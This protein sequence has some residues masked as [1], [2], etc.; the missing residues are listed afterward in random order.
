MQ[1]VVFELPSTDPKSPKQKK[2]NHGSGD[3]SVHSSADSSSL[4]SDDSSSIKK[5]KDPIECHPP[6]LVRVVG[7]DPRSKKNSTLEVCKEAVVEVAGGSYSQYLEPPRRKELAKIIVDA[8]AV[9]FPRG[10][11]FDLL[12]PWSGSNVKASNVQ[13][14][15]KASWRSSAEKILKRTGK[16]FRSAL[17]ISS[18]DIIV[19]VYAVGL[20]SDGTMSSDRSVIMNFYSSKCSEA[21]EIQIPEEVQMEYIGKVFMNLPAG[22]PRADAIRQFC[23]FL[24]A[25][26]AEDPG[27]PTLKVLEVDLQAKEKEKN[28]SSQGISEPIGKVL[29]RQKT[30]IYLEETGQLSPDDYMLTLSNRSLNEADGPEKGVLARIYEP[31]S[32]QTLALT[33]DGEDI[34]ELC[35]KFDEPDLLRDLLTARR[36]VN[37]LSEKN[38]SND[39]FVTEIEKVEWT[40]KIRIYNS[41]IC[42]YLVKDIGLMRSS[43][44]GT[45]SPLLGKKPQVSVVKLYSR[46]KEGKKGI[47]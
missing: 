1:I 34:Q 44:S 8:L 46:M 2:E 28:E 13:A 17:R 21:T 11:G 15:T 12:L 31:D 35:S 27:D 23:Q 42:D 3:S 18:F 33:Y 45:N 26:I 40:S 47:F 29:Y 38:K 37:D 19:S 9:H 24:R 7:Y 25:D 4:I 20:A 5:K 43:G 22:E 32:N 10:G 41:M 6:P 14:S 39:D 16:I 36:Y 30:A